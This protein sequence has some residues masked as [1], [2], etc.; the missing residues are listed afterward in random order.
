VNHK[1]WIRGVREGLRKKVTG[2]VNSSRGACLRITTKRRGRKKDVGSVGHC[3]RRITRKI[4]R[5]RVQRN[6]DGVRSKK[7]AN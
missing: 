3:Q 4:L 1:D 7:N 2:C 6:N 5:K